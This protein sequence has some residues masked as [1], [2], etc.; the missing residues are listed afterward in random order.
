MAGL[1]TV[2]CLEPDAESW[3]VGGASNLGQTTLIRLANG[4]G[5][6]ASAHI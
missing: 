5:T 3:L 2:A 4:S 1:A 6:D